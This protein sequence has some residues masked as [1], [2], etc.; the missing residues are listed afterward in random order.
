MRNKNG[1]CL[2]AIVALLLLP[3]T[4]EPVR[5]EP[6]IRTARIGVLAY[7]GHA[8]ALR[9]WSPTAE[10]LSD[11]IEGCRFE[12]VPLDLG[13][14][15]DATRDESIQFTLTN[16]GNYADLEA[17]FG[18]SRIATLQTR[19]D[20]R[21]RVRYGAVIIT[22]ADNREIETLE[23]LRG[24]SFMAVSE[25]AFGGFQMAWRELAEHSID[26]FQDLSELRFAGFP[27]DRIVLAVGNGSVDAATVRAET[28]ARM[29]ESG[30][31]DAADFRV[32]N[33]QPDTDGPFPLSTRLYPEWPFATLKSTPRKLAAQVTQALLTM[34]PDHPA[35]IA[36]RSAGWTIPLDY[37]PVTA[38]MQSLRIGPYEVLRETSLLALVKRYAYWF[39][40]A[41]AALVSL[42]ML[43]GY[44]TRTNRRLRETERNLRFEIREREASQEALAR[45]RDT[46]EET[47]ME[48]THDLR[49]TNQALEKSRVA[50][51][52]LVQITS[53]P[54][55][56]HD[57]RLEQLLETGREYFGTDV[58]VLASVDG[59]LHNVCK[60]S[61]DE[62]L[63]PQDTGPLN[64]R[65]AARLVEHHGEPLD[66]PDLA[67]CTDADPACR[68][69]G[70]LSY[71]GVG[72]M[73]DGRVHCTLEFAGGKSRPSP[74]SQWDH[75]LLKVMA[76][77]IGDELERQMAFESQ[78]RHE[79]E[80]ARVSRM[81]TI[82]EMAA[83][84]AHELNQ[85]LTGTINYSN[86]CLRL[87]KEPKPDTGKLIQGLQHAVE[88]ATLAADIIRHIRQFVQKGDDRYARV[89]LNQAVRNVTALISHEIQRHHIE[90][91]LELGEHLPAID[92]NLIQ[93]EQVIL[94][95][96]RNGIEAMDRADNA[97]RCL[98]IRTQASASGT[99]RLA[100]VDS[101][102][103]V[104]E[105]VL[106]KIF[107]AFFSTKPQGMGIGLSI[108]RSIVESHQGNINARALKTGG[109]E[110]VFELPAA[111]RS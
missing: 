104:A 76:Q 86:G 68:R 93:I 105:E 61:G 24:K 90:L 100:V 53:A 97:R 1:S 102:E 46:L 9:R 27:Q 4:T 55:L 111:N 101:G 87:L 43:N 107:D 67:A 32:L 25:E 26:P 3:L 89:D 30:V 8:Q 59:E 65:C 64:Q 29:I 108:S 35:A 62:R 34:P 88:G 33:P 52:Q 22:R 36:A 110:F 48:R 28:F 50:L 84:L 31:V 10:Y 54:E 21:I 57:Q 81:S 58:A 15:R 47:V 51:R 49:L 92:G 39:I 7:R 19:E 38:L 91:V 37:S 78:R 83:S 42:I 6:G 72:V 75:D 109:A 79:T 14:I 80:F 98:T 16:P 40:A 11:R 60:V 13:G 85:P 69:Q 63:A 99:V 20:E 23:D 71:L 45:Y 95:F 18:V 2:I 66:V 12:I 17:R 5:A 56:S 103:G 77:W 74:L 41:G 73:V 82:G 94:N 96:I 106:P 70:W 44:V